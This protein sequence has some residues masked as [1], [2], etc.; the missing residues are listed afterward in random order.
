MKHLMVDL[1]TMLVYSCSIYV[2]L[3]FL[4]SVAL[5]NSMQDYCC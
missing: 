2:S 4:G 1:A 3:V 5:V